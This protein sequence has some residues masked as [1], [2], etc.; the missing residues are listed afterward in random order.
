MTSSEILKQW[1]QSWNQYGITFDHKHIVNSILLHTIM[2]SIYF[3][4]YAVI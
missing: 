3:V 1:P 2:G 4:S